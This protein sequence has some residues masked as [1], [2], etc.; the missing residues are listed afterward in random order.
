MNDRNFSADQTIEQRGFA[1]IWAANNCD[2][3]HIRSAAHR[4][5]FELSLFAD[6]RALPPA[7]GVCP[8]GRK[9]RLRPK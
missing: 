2:I 8:P 5:N 6:A 3:R 4:V 7:I 1:N 9:P